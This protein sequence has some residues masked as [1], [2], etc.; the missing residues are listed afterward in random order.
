M[1]RINLLPHREARRERRK[2]DFVA[3]GAMVAMAGAA[4]AMAVGF[5]INSQ[6]DA[7]DRRN[8]FIAAENAK[9]DEQIREIATLRAEI[10]ALKARQQAVEELQSNR[11]IPVHLLDELVH[12][13]P[14]GI[15]L[16]SVSQTER[17]LAMVGYAQ[18]NERVAELLRNLAGRTEW[19]EKPELTE[20][21]AVDLKPRAGSGKD[22][23]QRRIYEFSLNAVVRSLTDPDKGG[24]PATV[25]GGGA[26]PA[27]QVARN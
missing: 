8:Q 18:T 23:E 24:A 22:A 10:D 6:I 26:T 4:V 17:R 5:G 19:L 27:A 12:N 25:A 9:L 16:K 21:K 13:T 14:E 11:T 3:L 7:Q 15:Y 20:I 1:I 2:R